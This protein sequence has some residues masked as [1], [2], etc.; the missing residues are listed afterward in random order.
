MSHQDQGTKQQENNIEINNIVLILVFLTF[1]QL[2]STWNYP[3][4]L[5]TIDVLVDSQRSIK[6]V[7][8][9]LL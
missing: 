6:A 2:S 8:D 4:T 3:S 5:A 1:C 9:V 7:I